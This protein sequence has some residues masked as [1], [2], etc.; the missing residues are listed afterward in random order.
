[1]C[2]T[3]IVFGDANWIYFT[4]QYLPESNCHYR[5]SFHCA[6]NNTVHGSARRLLDK[7]LI[8]NLSSNSR[9]YQWCQLQRQQIHRLIG[10]TPIRTTHHVLPVIQIELFSY[11]RLHLGENCTFKKS[12]TESW[13]FFTIYRCR[14]RSLARS[15]CQ[16]IVWKSS[17]CPIPGMS[18][19][20]VM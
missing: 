18:S 5:T 17:Y 4:Y 11:S 8:S 13:I 2:S 1:M 16:S 14:I 15:R 9:Q 12:Q 6:T 3:V 7:C 10:R 20:S 19:P